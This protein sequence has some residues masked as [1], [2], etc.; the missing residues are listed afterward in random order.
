VVKAMSGSKAED[1]IES[2]DFKIADFKNQEL[3][4]NV[5]IDSDINY[6]GEHLKKMESLPSADT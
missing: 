3:Y 2:T 4:M 6:M 5:K 1:Q